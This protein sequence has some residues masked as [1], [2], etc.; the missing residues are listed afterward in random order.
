MS[1]SGD[2]ISVL[3]RGYDFDRWYQDLQSACYV[4]GI[5]EI[6]TGQEA[7]L[8]EPKRPVLPASSDYAIT[9]A[10]LY[11]LQVY[12][13]DVSQYENQQ[14]RIRIAR[15]IIMSSISERIRYA[16]VMIKDIKAPADVVAFLKH[17]CEA[18]QSPVAELESLHALDLKNCS[19][20]SERFDLLEQYLIGFMA[21]EHYHVERDLIQKVIHSLPP[22]YDSVAQ[23]YARFASEPPDAVEAVFDR[24]IRNFRRDGEKPGFLPRAE[25]KRYDILGRLR[26]D[27]ETAEKEQEKLADEGTEVVLES[28]ASSG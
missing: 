16:I 2:F 24:Y 23:T 3:E 15:H 10:D 13:I 8:A 27:L 25:F 1:E 28:M 4:S 18:T 6:I 19:T 21:F 26:V 11:N 7:T 12:Q 17:I 22:A 9:V 20:I 5:W 14:E